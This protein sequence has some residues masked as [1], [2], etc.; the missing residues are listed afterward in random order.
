MR[1]D[2]GPKARG[3]GPVEIRKLCEAYARKYV[4]EQSVQ[5]Q[6]LGV[7]GRFDKPYITMDP[8]YEQGEMEVLAKLADEGLIHRELR[9]IHWCMHCGTALAEAEIEYQ[10]DEGPSIYVLFPLTDEAAA[11]LPAPLTGQHVHLMVWTTTPWTLPANLAVAVHPDFKYAAV[12][13]TKD[14]QDDGRHHG[15]R[16]GGPRGQGGGPGRDRDA[17]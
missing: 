17:R 4:A 2:L 13:F 1:Q 3:M 7:L 15:R 9:A 11:K 16:P 6:T 14:G 8:A 10:D 5:F 12:R